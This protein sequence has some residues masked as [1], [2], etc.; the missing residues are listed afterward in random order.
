MSGQQ[1]V[2]TGAYNTCKQIFAAEVSTRSQLVVDSD[3]RERQVLSS[4][5]C[6]SHM[7]PSGVM[8]CPA[9]LPHCPSRARSPWLLRMHFMEAI[10]SH[11]NANTFVQIES[12][13]TPRTEGR[14]TARAHALQRL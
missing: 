8:G 5:T 10:D 13:S 1:S 12:P 2:Q 4:T 6:R 7:S 3:M 11:V 9:V 14:S